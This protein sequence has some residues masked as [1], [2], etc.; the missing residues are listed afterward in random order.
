[1]SRPLALLGGSLALGL[2]LTSCGDDAD[3]A[4]LEG[5]WELTNRNGNDYPR[6]VEQISGGVEQGPQTTVAELELFPDGK[7]YLTYTSTFV[8]MLSKTEV[9]NTTTWD[10][11]V[12]AEDDPAFALRFNRNDN[13][14]TLDCTLEDGERLLCTQTAPTISSGDE[15]PNYGWSFQRLSD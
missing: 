9:V 6:V 10:A 15:P 1:M 4:A 12:T 8:T 2:S 11:R 14:I 7:G 13:L 5:V 3:V